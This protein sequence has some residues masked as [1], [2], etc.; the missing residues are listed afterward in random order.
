MVTCG[1]GLDVLR[2]AKALTP[3]AA[4]ACLSASPGQGHQGHQGC[5]LKSLSTSHTTSVLMLRATEVF[6]KGVSNYSLAIIPPSYLLALAFN[7]CRHLQTVSTRVLP[8][9]TSEKGESHRPT[10]PLLYIRPD[11]RRYPVALLQTMSYFPCA[12]LLFL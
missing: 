6:R 5:V 3:A 12:V 9:A 10:N 8:I 1:L 11:L 7:C 2:W 4:V